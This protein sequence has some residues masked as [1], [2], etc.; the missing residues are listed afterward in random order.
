MGSLLDQLQKKSRVI[1][2]ISNPQIQQHQY[3]KM[4]SFKILLVVALVAF[5][6]SSDALKCKVGTGAGA[7][8][9]DCK[10]EE[11]SC[12]IEATITIAAKAGSIKSVVQ[13]CDTKDLKELTKKFVVPVE[14]H[15][16]EE[17]AV[18][19]LPYYC[20]EELCNVQ[21]PI[22]AEI[23]T[24]EKMA[25]LLTANPK[26]DDNPKNHLGPKGGAAQTTV[27]VATIAFS[28]VMARLAL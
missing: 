24:K 5:I 11:K 2:Y 28:M 8:D 26:G 22:E 15:D 6:G 7:V 3:D 13:S 17:G 10:T 20:S 9:T 25:E 4:A 19:K 21:A 12:K 1:I 14:L 23:K 16:L 27:A 18:V